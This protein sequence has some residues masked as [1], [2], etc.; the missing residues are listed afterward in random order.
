MLTYFLVAE[1]I[2]S[3]P[4]HIYHLHTGA[5]LGEHNGLWNFTIGQNARIAGL[6]TKAFVAEKSRKNNAIYVVTD[7]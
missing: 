6:P 3:Q 1:Y 2:P 4:G 5:R 7:P